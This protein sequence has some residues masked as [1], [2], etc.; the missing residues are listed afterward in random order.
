VI[1]HRAPEETGETLATAPENVEVESKK[2]GGC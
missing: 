2:I 1:A